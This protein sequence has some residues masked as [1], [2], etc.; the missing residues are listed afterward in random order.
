[1]TPRT[2]SL[3]DELALRRIQAMTEPT[4]FEISG[5]QFSRWLAH[6]R[7]PEYLLGLRIMGLRT[8]TPR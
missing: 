2:E 4:E 8:Y 3:L 5:V 1:M 7:S 6:S